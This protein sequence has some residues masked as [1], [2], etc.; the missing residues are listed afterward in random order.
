MQV[1]NGTHVMTQPPAALDLHV[2]SIIQQR[3]FGYRVTRRHRA[4]FRGQPLFWHADLPRMLEAG[5]RGACLGIHYFPWE[6]KRAFAEMNRQI[7][8]L[9]EVI[10][11]DERVLRVRGPDDWRRAGREGLLALAPGVEG[12]HMLGADL[13]HVEALAARSIA[14]L[15]LTHFSKNAAAT[16]S[17]GRGANESDGLSGF[18]R[19]LISALDDHEITIDLA[20]L[21]TPGVLEACELA[22]RP[23][24]CTHTGVKGVHEHARNISDDEIDAIAATGGVIGVIFAPIFLAGRLRVDSGVVVDHIEYVIERVGVRHVAI[25]SDYDGWIPSIPSDQ[26]DCRDIGRVSDEL[27]ARGYPEEAVERI[28]WKN[29]LEV[30]SGQR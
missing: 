19:E 14:Y 6:S 29:A 25:G 9:D 18:G 1:I 8:Y 11:A 16:P 13:G 17:M 30:L 20:H 22:S 3:L 12:A 2:D 27:Y 15:T 4:G 24:L 26:R 28:F 21:N 7:D 5:Y 23:L 10:G